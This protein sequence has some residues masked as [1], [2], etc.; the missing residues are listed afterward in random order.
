MN[1][2]N[3]DELKAIEKLITHEILDKSLCNFMSEI[4]N[5]M[6]ELNEIRNKYY[7]LKRELIIKANIENDII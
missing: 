1:I 7:E 4:E 3:Q 6:L 2:T 5:L